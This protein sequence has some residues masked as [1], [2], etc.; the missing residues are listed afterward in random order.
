MPCSPGIASRASAEPDN[1][2]AVDS[3][4]S[5]VRNDDRDVIVVVRWAQ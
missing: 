3:D 5:A 4:R 2:C 1:R